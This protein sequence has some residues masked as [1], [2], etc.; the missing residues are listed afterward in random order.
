M[1][2]KKTAK[3]NV[4][5]KKVV[6]IIKTNKLFNDAILPHPVCLCHSHFL[7]RSICFVF[8]REQQREMSLGLW[9]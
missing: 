4:T 3:K 5:E 7:T 9:K 2:A 6:S 1:K 8:R